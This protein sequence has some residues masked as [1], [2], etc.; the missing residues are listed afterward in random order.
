VEVIE[1]R[2]GAVADYA[3][4][5]KAALPGKPVDIDA[6]ATAIAAYERTFE[7]GLAPFD[8]WVNGSEVAVSDSAKRGF[9]LFNNKALC[10]A[11]HG[12][13]R[14]TDDK[15]HDIGTSTTDLGRG[16]ELANDPQMQ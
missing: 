9:V 6:I 12:G 8:R 1:Q 13:W 2:I 15:F 3:E 7:P 11:C 4:R 16:R 10:F 14:F 5:F